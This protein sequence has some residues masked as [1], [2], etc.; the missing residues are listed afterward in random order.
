[1]EQVD[2]DDEET[3]ATATAFG[4]ADPNEKKA[5]EEIDQEDHINDEYKAE[6]EKKISINVIGSMTFYKWN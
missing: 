1:M 5:G 4:T 3:E 6:L 2:E